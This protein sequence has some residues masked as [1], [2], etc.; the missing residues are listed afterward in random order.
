LPLNGV[1]IEEESPVK[2][3]FWDRAVMVI[4]GD[5]RAREIVGM[6]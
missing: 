5:E 1:V 6:S 4:S 3:E 2:G